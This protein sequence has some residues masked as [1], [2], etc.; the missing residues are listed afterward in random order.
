MKNY[1]KES[2]ITLITLIITILVVIIVA[3]VAIATITGEDG[4]LSKA[5][6]TDEE[7]THSEVKEQIIF[8]YNA[9]QI[10]KYVSNNEQEEKEIAEIASIK[11]I[12]IAENTTTQNNT[13]MQNN[14]TTQNTTTQ[15][16]TTKTI[17]FWEYLLKKQ[18][19]EDNG[20]VNVEKLLGKKASLGN[21]TGDTD[22]YKFELKDGE[23]SLS[24]IKSATEIIKIWN[25]K[26]NDKVA[27]TID[28]AQFEYKV[29]ADG[30]T[31]TI[32]ELKAG[33]GEDYIYNDFGNKGKLVKDSNGNVIEELKIPS[34]I[35]NYTVTGIKE[36]AFSGDM[37]H[38]SNWPSFRFIYVPN[39]VTSIGSSAFSGWDRL[40]KV[41]I[42]KGSSLSKDSANYGSWIHGRRQNLQMDDYI[43]FK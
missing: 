10:D 32:T 16:T 31:I 12:K 40:E 14:T 26:T 25:V 22:I 42:E 38:S 3:G 36:N 21:G 28:P 9:Y 37:G 2:A 18:Y 41:Y 6:K 7:Q 27:A 11:T 39:T 43:V 15:N 34:K 20:K 8:E 19:I 30:K 13:T 1:K 23:Y 5:A 17:T 24:Y 33:F 35:D 29:N 4:I